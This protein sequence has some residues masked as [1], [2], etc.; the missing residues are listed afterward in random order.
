MKYLQWICLIICASIL[1]SC[2]STQ[3]AGDGN[4]ERKHL[5]AMREQNEQPQLDESE[6][7]LWNAQ[8]NTI[9]MDGNP[10]R[11]L[12]PLSKPTR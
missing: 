10:M 11:Q 4:Q 5:A 12:E 6:Q 7:N 9:N 1:T 2:E 8:Q 3:T